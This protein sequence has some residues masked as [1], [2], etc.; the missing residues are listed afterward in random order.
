MSD[1]AVGFSVHTVWAASVTLVDWVSA[2]RVV[3]RRRLTLVETSE[4]DARFVYHAAA[5]LDALA[6]AAVVAKAQNVA[7]T[8]A[9]QALTKLLEDLS[10]AGHSVSAVGLPVARSG[11]PTS[12]DDL[13]RSHPRIHAAEGELFCGALVDAALSRGLR[14]VPVP[15]KKRLEEAAR[16][17]GWRVECVRT[18]VGR[19]GRALGPPWALAQ[20]E[21]AL[22]A[23]IAGRRR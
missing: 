2:P 5:E 12:L 19:L 13:L 10:A 3:D 8:Q 16:A 20:K 22:A 14:V 15:A 4:H 6:G 7:R 18:S 11:E 9:L 21:A 1:A 23:L 17:T